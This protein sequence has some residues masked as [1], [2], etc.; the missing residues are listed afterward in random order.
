MEKALDFCICGYLNVFQVWGVLIKKSNWKSNLKLHVM[1]HEGSSRRRCMGVGS[2]RK[3]TTSFA[4]LVTLFFSLMAAV[5]AHA[6]VTGATL[7][8]T[9]T[10]PSGGVVANATVSAA[11]AATA[12]TRDV[13]S[14]SSGLYTIP[15]LV[16]G[17]Y[18]I[19]VSAT[20][21]STS[22]QSALTLSVG[23]QLQLNFALKVGNT[24]TTVQVTE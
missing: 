7:S 14:D 19:R 22:V 4:I 11:N 6:Q 12:I 2:F 20:G 23:Q 13:T 21:F 16:P 8:G 18:D 10:D 9:V 24:N 3:L 15:N 1:T 5:V 17:V